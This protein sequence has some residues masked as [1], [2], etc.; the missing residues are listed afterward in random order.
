MRLHRRA[1]IDRI[2]GE[3][4]VQ[5]GR[6]GR[7]V[8]LG[9]LLAFA[10]WLGQM[11][12]GPALY[13]HSEGMVLGRVSTIATEFSATVRT[14]PLREGDR[15][16]AGEIVSVVTSQDVAERIAQLTAQ[17]ADLQSK[18]SA[19]AIRGG[20]VGRLRVAAK[21]R[22]EVT[23]EARQALERLH[24]RRLLLTKD[25]LNVFDSEY[26]SRVE[27]ETLEA[28][29]TAL[30]SEAQALRQR[31]DEASD[32]LNKLEKL[33]AGGEL[34]SPIAGVVGRLYVSPGAVVR[35]GD[36]LMDVYEDARFVLAYVP[37][38]A[39]YEVL[40]GD[41]VSIRYGLAEWRGTVERVEPV[42][43][44]LPKEFQSSFKPVDRARVLRIAME[45]G[46][47]LPPLFSKI[48]VKADDWPPSWMVRMLPWS[49]TRSAAAAVEP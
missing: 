1:R 23:A 14:Q 30:G 45:N 8:Y 9:I 11:F 35:L 41:P 12:F 44:Q 16:S 25:R 20:V 13:F 21:D 19:L 31:M 48:T 32:A 10:V 34:R 39:I 36:P 29:R 42:A 17:L 47:S 37:A 43:S 27:T 38:G 7:W 3:Q 5:R 26:R 15:V 49:G 33:Y 28:E 40:P 22:A 2:Q 6:W 4:R 46:D 24:D 18:K